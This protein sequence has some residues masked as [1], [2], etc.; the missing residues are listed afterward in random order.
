MTN[1]ITICCDGGS[2]GNPGP[3]AFGYIIY[4]NQRKIHIQNSHIQEQKGR[5]YFLE[6]ETIT[7][8]G[9]YLG[10][11]TNNVA[12]WSGLLE[13]LKY[14]FTQSDQIQKLFKSNEKEDKVIIQILLDS[15]LVIE[16]IQGN[17]KVKQEHLKP[18]FTQSLELIKQIPQKYNLAN[19]SNHL[20]F[21]YYHI[22][23]EYNKISDTIV[24]DILDQ[25]INNN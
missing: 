19:S 9:K 2:R 25:N 6:S 20:T 13:A 4:Y 23:R 22:Y 7:Q 1:Y 8:G 12:E 16:Q 14:I 24:N 21:E 18:F 11:T 5:D 15:N 3:A 17:W 10:H